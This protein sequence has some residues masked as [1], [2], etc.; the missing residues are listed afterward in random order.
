MTAFAS[1]N[2]TAHAGAPL[3]TGTPVARTGDVTAALQT[4]FDPEIPINIYDLGLIYAIRIADNGKTDI[5]MTLTTPTC[6]IAGMLPVKVARTAAA[7]PG[8]GEVRVFLVWDPPWTPECMSEIAR[9]ALEMFK[10]V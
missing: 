4:V 7:V 2:F 9:S 3:L 10:M 5:Q 6:P 1:K 8:V